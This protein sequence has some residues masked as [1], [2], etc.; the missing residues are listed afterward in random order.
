LDAI[1][2]VNIGRHDTQQMKSSQNV[3]TSENIG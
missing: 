3:R 1:L 2:N